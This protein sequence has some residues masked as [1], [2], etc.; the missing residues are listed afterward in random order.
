[1]SGARSAHHNAPPGS[2]D[3][4]TTAV[5]REG[6]AS[7]VR[8]M[9]RSMIRSSY[10]S[11]IYEGY[12]FSCVIIDGTGQLLAQSGEDHPFHI[13]PVA[14]SVRNLLDR[15]RAIGPDDTFLHNDPYS[16]GTHLNDVAVVWPVFDGAAVAFFI[17]IRSHWADVGG[18]TPGSL[19]GGA[20]E[21]LQEGLRLDNLRVG[22]SGESEVLRL[23]FDNV[24]VSDEAM[25]DFHAVLGILRVAETRLRGIMERY[26]AVVLAG[27][28]ADLLDSSERRM[29]AVIDELPDGIYPG[30]AYLDGND[31]AHFPLRV[32][33]ALRVSGD[34]VH[35]DFAGTSGQIAAPLNAGPAIAVTSV[36][37][38]LKSFLDPAGI[39]TSGTLRPITVDVPE[40]T[41]LNAR[42]PAPCGGLNE[43]RFAADAAMLAALA[44]MI[45]EQVTGDVRGTSNHTYIGGFD[46]R[47]G[48]PFI[49]YEYPSG[50]TGGWA[51]H[52]GNPAVR[53]FN[54]G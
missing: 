14:A 43:V 52:D 5:I 8:E 3:F 50:G 28:I 29:R 39:I 31:A 48:K 54:E 26:G 17:V 22:K 2:P 33:V 19:S 44:Q 46:E 40:R 30:T 11:I 27:A 1:M 12:D 15:G 34:A 37:T 36:L 13:I 23:I 21:I 7:I 4:I 47:R 16:G 24:R 6:L 42:F 18:T 9:R 35:A 38:I 53:A 45:P 20:R 49:F 25:S 41:I 51:N 10:S 32:S